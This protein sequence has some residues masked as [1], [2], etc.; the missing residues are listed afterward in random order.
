MRE[1]EIE[2]KAARVTKRATERGEEREVKKGAERESS[3]LS[4]SYIAGGG[5]QT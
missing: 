1:N 4:L 2:R 5:A 3:A